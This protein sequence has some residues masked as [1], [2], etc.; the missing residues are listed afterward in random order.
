[1]NRYRRPWHSAIIFAG[2][3]VLFFAGRVPVHVAISAEPPKDSSSGSL[4][5]FFTVEVLDKMDSLP[6]NIGPLPAVTAP[7]N[8]PTTPAKV[9]LGRQLFFD[10]R[11]SGDNRFSCAWCHNPSLAFGDGL[12]R[13]S[14]FGNKEL[15]RH[16]PTVLNAA[17]SAKQF[18]DGRADTLEDQ[19]K[20]PITNQ[21]EMNINPENLVKKLSA[22]PTYQKQFNTV[23]GAAPSLDT[24]AMAIAAYERTLVTPDTPYD[25]YMKGDKKALTEQQKRGLVLFISRAACSRCHNGPN[26]SDDKFHNLAVP[27]AGPLKDDLGRYG[28]THDEKDRRAFRTVTLR[29]VAL[30][31]PYMHNGAFKTLE[32]VVDFYNKGGGNDPNKDPEIFELH[33]TAEE[34]QDLIA[35]LKALNGWTPEL[36]AIATGNAN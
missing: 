21:D 6:G 23:F 3:V 35:F 19:A 22:I 24:V 29:N 8:N 13:A 5:Q 15:N 27:P 17:Y 2:L 32:E 1:M 20:G 36:E 14:G 12:P 10:T 18:W 30:T 33:L 7:K 11:L 26:L 4:N 25:R 28:V 16:S 34:Q 31:A 9:A